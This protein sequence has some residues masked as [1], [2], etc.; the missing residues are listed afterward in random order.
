MVGCY[1]INKMNKDGTEKP[2]KK[3]VD[4]FYLWMIEVA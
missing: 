1:I 3:E 2:K 4:Q